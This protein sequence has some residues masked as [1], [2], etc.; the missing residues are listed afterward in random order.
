MECL[1]LWCHDM[2]IKK[3]LMSWAKELFFR[4][5]GRLACKSGDM[6]GPTSSLIAKSSL[7]QLLI[8]VPEF[9][10]CPV[11]IL[12]CAGEGVT[13]YS[14]R[15]LLL[16]LSSQ[17]LIIFTYL[18]VMCQQQQVGAMPLRL[19]IVMKPLPACVQCRL[20]RGESPPL[21]PP[22][23]TQVTQHRDDGMLQG[24][25]KKHRGREQNL[26]SSFLCGLFFFFASFPFHPRGWRLPFYP[27]SPPPPRVF[28]CFLRGGFF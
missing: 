7:R 3:F 4:H 2:S 8:S 16:S 1:D 9:L 26:L 15:F 14:S 28:F 22:T 21:L 23:H 17:W 11:R 20:L 19:I 27:D 5:V 25:G 18:G 24:G 10:Y 12:F 6:N 13:L